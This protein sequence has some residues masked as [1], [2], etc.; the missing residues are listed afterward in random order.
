MEKINLTIDGIDISVAKGSTILQAAKEAKVDIPTL[1]FL[2]GVHEPGSCRICVVEVEGWRGLQPACVTK[3]EEGIVVKTSSRLVRE[4]R[5]DILELILANHNRECLSC[6]RNQKCELQ[7]LAEDFGIDSNYYEKKGTCVELDQSGPVVRDT[8]K[9]VLCGRCVSVCSNIQKVNAIDLAYRGPNTSVTTPYEQSL[10]LRSCINCGQCIKVCP[11]GALQE[12]DDTEKVWKALEDP[13]LHVVVQ[14]APAVRVALG[15]EFGLPVG[16]NVK[17]KMVTALKRLGF[18]KI[19]DTTFGADL[20]IM[21]E[22]TEL[23]HRINNGGKLPLI[24]SCSPG[25]VKFCEHNYSDFLDNLSSCRSPQQMFGAVAKSYYP[26]KAGLDANKVFVVSVMPCTAKKF[27][28][29]REELKINGLKDVDAV[30]TTRELAKMI[31]QA[32]I[33]FNEL[34][35]S[36]YDELLGTSTGAGVIFANTG[37]VMEAALRTVA[38]ILTG[39][40]LQTIEYHEVRG[41]EGTKEATVNINGMELNVAI[42]HGTG[43]AA[44]L[45][46]TIR[47]G[48]AD[49]HFIEVMACPGG[50]INGGG[51]PILMDKSKTQ[52][53]NQLR[54]ASIYSLDRTAVKRKSHDN[55]EIKKIYAEFLDKPGSSKAHQLLHTHYIARN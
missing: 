2:Q 25:W 38:D 30:I 26:Q 51:Q 6:K 44:K 16:T 42:A 45:L 10:S 5:R 41:L 11:V 22:G 23:L 36:Y 13:E 28:A 12:R 27:E 54:A 32:G 3:A 1:C 47:E 29:D 18:N 34:S 48:K 19:F 37:G 7:K 14:T 40:D 33:N 15:E 8:S 21:E 46:D 24:T 9:C 20:T 53:V 17:G 43:N 52:E 39:E 50:C 35:D 49:Y 55:P 31:K 4:T